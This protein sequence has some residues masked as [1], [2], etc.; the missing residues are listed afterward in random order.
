MKFVSSFALGK[1]RADDRRRRKRAADEDPLYT[2][3]DRVE[4][5]VDRKVRNGVY[6][7][8]PHPRG[9]GMYDI[10]HVDPVTLLPE[11]EGEWTKG[12]CWDKRFGEG[13]GLWMWKDKR[14]QFSPFELPDSR[15]R[16]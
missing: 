13:H 4:C 15:R 8:I 11:E 10:Q 12:V 14:E 7:G 2:E 16:K 5:Y 3:T 6:P 9:D 1:Y